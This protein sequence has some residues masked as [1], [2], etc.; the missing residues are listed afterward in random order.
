MSTDFQSAKMNLK[1]QNGDA[2]QKILEN[3]RLK[4]GER[5]REKDFVILDMVEDF[6][7]PIILGRSLL[8]TTYAKI[9]VFRKLISIEDIEYNMDNELL[10]IDP[11]LFLYITSFCIK[12]N[13]FNY[14]LSNNEDIFTCEFYVQESEEEWR[15]YLP[16]E[17]MSFEDWLRVTHG[18]MNVEKLQKMA[19]AVRTGGK[20]SVR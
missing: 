12:T 7:M 2:K 11:N 14:L 9:D 6:R 17:G 4:S 10:K 8:A 16:W 13:E 1:M 20:G 3:Y 19:G 18:K 5:K 15:M